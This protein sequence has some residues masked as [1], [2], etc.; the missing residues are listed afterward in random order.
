MKNIQFILTFFLFSPFSILG[1]AAPPSF[2]SNGC[3]ESP[4][5]CSLNE[6]NGYVGAMEN[7]VPDAPP[8]P[9]TCAGPI[10]CNNNIWFSFIAT[11]TTETIT[12]DAFNCGSSPIQPGVYGMKGQVFQISDCSTDSGFTAVSNCFEN[13]GGN[14]DPAPATLN[15]SGLTPGGI[16][17]IMLDGF[18]GSTCEFSVAVSPSASPAPVLS[19]LT[20]P[21]D[22]CPGQYVTY[23]VDYNPGLPTIDNYLIT[24]SG[25]SPD[26]SAPNFGMPYFQG[27]PNPTQVCID[28]IAG[29]GSLS[30][31]FTGANDCYPANVL[32]LDANSQEIVNAPEYATI[33]VTNGEY[34]YWDVSGEFY[35]GINP[36]SS[37]GSWSYSEIT[38]EGCTSDYKLYID[39]CYAPLDSFKIDLIC[40]SDLPY[41]W[42]GVPRNSA[43]LYT[44]EIENPD[45]NDC[46]GTAQLQLNVLKN[47]A[48]IAVPENISCL[49]GNDQV[50]LFGDLSEIET[51]YGYSTFSWST[52][53]GNITSDTTQANI[54]VNE[55]GIYT[56]EVTSY[57]DFFNNIFTCSSFADVEVFLEPETIHPVSIDG[58]AENCGETTA[59][60]LP[61]LSSNE[62]VEPNYYW[63]ADGGNLTVENGIAS[64]EWINS[65]QICLTAFNDCDTTE[66]SCLEV[67]H[68]NLPIADFEFSYQINNTIVFENKSQFGNNYLWKFGDDTESSEF[69][70]THTYNESGTYQ[71]TLI[72]SNDCT[73]DTIIKELE[74][75]TPPTADFT[76]IPRSGC[77]PLTIQFE[78]TS[79]GIVDNFL[80][81]FEG[82][83][84]A[85][86]TEA[87]P[88]ITFDQPGNLEVSLEVSNGAGANQIIQT[89]IEVY[90]NP[91][92]TFNYSVSNLSVSFI[93]SSE[94]EDSLLWNFGDGYTS[95][96]ESPTHSYT[97]SGDYEVIL[98]SNNDCGSDTSSQII[99]VLIPPI[100]SFQASTI[101]GCIP[102]TIQFEST[103]TGIVDNFLWTFEGGNP[104]TSTEANPSITF[105]QPGNLEVSLEVSNDAGANQ[106]IQTAIEVY[107]DPI[108]AFNYSV[109]NL[110]VSFI[111]SSEYEDSLLWNFG[112]GYTSTEESPTHIYTESG[113][114]EV[115]LISNNDCGSDTSSQIIS[116]LIPPIASFQASTIEGCIPLTIQFE[117]TSTGIVDNFLWTFEGGNP[118]TSTEANPSVTFDQPG[119]LEVSLEV[120]N[121]AGAN[122]II[123]TAIEVYPDPI[124]TFNYSVSN[125]SVSFINSSEYEDSLLWNFGD[126]YTSTEE[127]PTHSYTESGDYEVSLISNN[128]C[129]S[130]TSSQIISVLIPPIASFQASTIEGCIPLTIQ[131]ENTSTGIVDNFLWTFEGG[132]PATSTEANPEIVFENT[133][134]FD[135]SLEVSNASGS[136]ELKGL[137]LIEVNQEP[138]AEFEFALSGPV[139]YFSNYSQHADTYLWDFGDN[140][141]SS[142]ENPM[143]NYEDY[144]SYIITLTASNLCGEVTFIDS[145]LFTNTYQIGIDENIFVYPNPNKGIFKID[146]SET[147]QVISSIKI[148]NTIGQTIKTFKTD[149]EGQIKIDLHKEAAGVYYVELQSEKGLILKRVI[150]E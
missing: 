98:I 64:V 90:P 37:D 68:F 44:G 74:T 10:S 145:V 70:P 139:V 150:K 103:S 66:I 122:Q 41:I 2:G 19:N 16:Y 105:D 73:S 146:W 72:S 112:D 119:N 18:A 46:E 149:S 61:I 94:Y 86:S 62:L 11:N 107:P 54:Q 77:G 69:N 22:L 3:D 17:T 104:A 101:E 71:I 135:V 51:I 118:A 4:L 106:I 133:G 15:L 137:D 114:Y 127:S 25:F 5:L 7:T 55:P 81:T 21:T 142:E 48:V 26:F 89:A 9:L 99:S 82:G 8:C 23:C 147:N 35:Y 38:P 32:E 75:L 63:T 49:P 31:E 115:S 83:N 111:N 60:Y 88:S 148:Y 30:V 59:E 108:S 42:L 87:N 39:E 85:T 95:T 27:S 132:N 47:N 57:S 12:V 141:I 93:N 97:E 131:F 124:S 123:Q 84:P 130:D 67:E 79:T 91:I 1:Q 56:L 24:Y 80:W 76:F 13:G 14:P 58:P 45:C 36:S 40:S 6:L 109:S 92:S 53:N 52:Q 138:I 126:G 102:L 20:G 33:C 100:A 144:G 28:L 50:T 136:N 110:S 140:N 117:S 116:V 128:D 143:H 34:Y 43:G 121:D 129:G 113:D 134:I 65:G 125:L 96:E 29:E 78:S 120:S